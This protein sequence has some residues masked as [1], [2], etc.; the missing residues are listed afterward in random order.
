MGPTSM[1]RSAD[2]NSDETAAL[3]RGNAIRCSGLDRYFGLEV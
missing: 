3:L 2:L 1:V